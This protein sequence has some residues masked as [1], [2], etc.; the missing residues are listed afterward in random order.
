MHT[1]L[2]LFCISSYYIGG[3]DHVV[4]WLKSADLPSLYPT[5]ESLEVVGILR[6]VMDHWSC[7]VAQVG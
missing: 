6:R 4:N 3:L 7:S 5:R 2:L 1:S